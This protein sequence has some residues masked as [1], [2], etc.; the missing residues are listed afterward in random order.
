MDESSFVALKRECSE[1]LKTYVSEAKQMCAMLRQAEGGSLTA[2]ALRE[3]QRQ[4]SQ[5]N[6]LH[7]QYMEVRERLF[8]VVHLGRSPSGS[9]IRAA[10]NPSPS[11]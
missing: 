11:L 7:R 2:E 3:L 6:E 8:E 4:R 5:E 10:K 9:P 1:M